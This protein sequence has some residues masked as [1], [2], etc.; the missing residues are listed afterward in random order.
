ML[1]NLAHFVISKINSAVNSD[2]T[3]EKVIFIRSIEQIR[4]NRRAQRLTRED[5]Q[6]Q[7]KKKGLEMKGSCQ[8][9]FSDQTM[10]GY[11]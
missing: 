6:T 4:K 10:I 9:T 11:A 2:K 5:K 1:R 7:V 3:K 8:K